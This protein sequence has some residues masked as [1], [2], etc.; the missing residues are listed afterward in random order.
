MLLK[1][2]MGGEGRSRIVSHEKIIVIPENTTAIRDCIFVVAA[3]SGLLDVLQHI[4]QRGYRQG[5]IDS[6]TDAR[7]GC[8]WAFTSDDRVKGIC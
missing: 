5:N 3:L 7:L 1:V 8:F 6:S 4:Q 2:R